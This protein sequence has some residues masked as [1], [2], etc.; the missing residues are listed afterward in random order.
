MKHAGDIRSHNQKSPLFRSLLITFIYAFFGYVWIISSELF[1]ARAL[2]E[3][4]EVFNISI[5]KGLLFVT[6]TAILIFI[7]VYTN[8]RKVHCESVI[9]QESEN[10]LKEAQHLAHVG[11]FSYNA[12]N[13]VYTFSDEAI[14][15]LD[16]NDYDKPITYDLLMRK[17]QIGDRER[18][19][20]M[21]TEAAYNA[22][23]ELAFDCRILRAHES[24]RTVQVR[25]QILLQENN[26]KPFIFGTLQDVTE[27]AQAEAAAR[28]NEAIYKALLNSSYDLVYLKDSALRY[29]AVNTNMQRYYGIQEQDLIGKQLHDIKP[30]EDALL[31]ESRDRKVLLSGKPVFIEDFS[32]GR[33][34]ETIIFPVDLSNQKRGVGGISR[35]ITQRRQTEQVIEQERDRAQTYFD[36][37]AVIFVAF[38]NDGVVTMINRT[39]CDVLGL[40]KEEIIGKQW[41]ANFVPESDRAMVYDVMHRI[42]DGTVLPTD[43]NENGILNANHDVYRVEWRNVALKDANGKMTGILSAGI[44]VTDLHKTIEAL[45]ESERSKSVLLSNLPGMAYRCSYDRNWT[46]HFASTGCFA[47]TG[48]LPEEL[49]EN[50]VLSFNDIIC[51]EYREVIW[52]DSVNHLTK[53]RGNRYEY[54]IMTASGERKWVLDI[55]Q[56]ILD[57]SGNIVALEGIIIDITNTKL[58]FL[59]IQY[60]SDHDQLTGVHN[61]Q[62]YDTAKKRFDTIA[63]LPLSV[64]FVDIN[65]LKLINDAFGYDAGDHIIQTTAA[66]LKSSMKSGEVLARVGGDEFGILLPHTDMRMCE[67]RMQE[68]RDA[69]ISHNSNEKDLSKVINLSIGFSTK[70]DPSIEFSQVEKEAEENMSRRKLFDQKSH[71]NAVLSSIMTTLFERSFETKEHAERI[72]SFCAI[73]GERLN[74]PQ[75]DIDRLRL[76]A[77][78]HDIGKIAISDQILNKPSA[79]NEEELKV[80]RTHPEIG[81]RI[82]MSSPD[83]AAI[84]DLILTHHERWDGK[85]Y[86]NQLAGENIPLLSRILAVADAYDAMT[87]DRVYRKALSREVAISEIR[88]NAGTQFDPK[89]AKVFLEILEEEDNL[90]AADPST[91]EFA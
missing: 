63:F 12:K 59:Q 27:R 34:F 54:E 36:I 47:L 69:F 30:G 15:I 76:F 29:V 6:A 67:Q 87:E 88:K 68:F 79:L 43:I 72:G 46:M 2:H 26:K 16:L 91:K 48:Y 23:G 40:P 5:T 57:E 71:H 31:W 84:A 19:Y 53:N 21:T 37:A 24:E 81:Y 14:N 49:V 51:P 50:R 83:L 18:V 41:M 11:N 60:L 45:R 65:G 44:D 55:N 20:A 70:L 8:L 80:M 17:V 35:D 78:L 66:V 52:N 61:R 74:L 32:D 13:G 82:A 85:G 25:L 75:D 62:Y 1:V 64:F 10:A 73:I 4:K 56:G 33:F 58:Q 9:R 89:V 86:P 7:L 39:G 22:G 90:Q 38:D 3:S 77:M 28:E 42:H